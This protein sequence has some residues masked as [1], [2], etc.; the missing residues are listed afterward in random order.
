MP[1]SSPGVSEE[2]ATAPVGPAIPAPDSGPANGNP[3]V[4]V[5]GDLPDSERVARGRLRR[6]LLSR[7]SIQS[8]L[9]MMLILSSVLSAAVVGLIGYQSGRNSLRESVFEHLTE[10]RDGQ[11]AQLQAKI[12]DLTNS[13]II[14]TRGSTTIDA[15]AA[16]TA[17]FDQLNAAAISPQQQK[18]LVD[19]YNSFIGNTARKT[20]EQLDLQALL[21]NSNVQKYLQAHYTAPFNGWRCDPVRRRPRRQRVVRGPRAVQRLLPRD[22]HQVRLRRCAADRRP[23]NVVYSAYKGVDLGTNI[24]NGPYRES[25]LARRLRE[26]PRSQRRRLRGRHR[27]RELPARRMSRPRGW[28]PRWAPAGQSPGRAR[29]AVP[30]RRDQPAD[31]LRQAVGTRRHG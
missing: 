29:A 28:W 19:Y 4:V 13:L 10:V 26:G 27:L 23:G 7:I 21:P 16:F 2:P 20:G 9:I 30:D 12:T 18:Q 31:D 14:Y 3:E 25:D 22:R 1:P 6:R 17:G 15:L 5:G 8:K 24:L 11:T